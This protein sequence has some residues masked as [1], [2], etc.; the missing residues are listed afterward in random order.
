MSDILLV[1]Q[2]IQ[3]YMD[4]IKNLHVGVYELERKTSPSYNFV[5]NLN[6]IFGVD[7]NLKITLKCD[8]EFS[9]VLADQIKELLVVDLMHTSYGRTLANKYM[10]N[11]IVSRVYKVLEEKIFIQADRVGGEIQSDQSFIG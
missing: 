6:G 3:G 10:Y 8:T 11:K 7:H 4:K 2:T 1:Y 9:K 5:V